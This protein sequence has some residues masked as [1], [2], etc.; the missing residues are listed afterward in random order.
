M[1]E[2]KLAVVKELGEAKNRDGEEKIRD[3]ELKNAIMSAGVRL[4][5]RITL[6]SLTA[7]VVPLFYLCEKLFSFSQ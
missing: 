1:E 3:E 6:F 2:F 5:R 4:E 7:L